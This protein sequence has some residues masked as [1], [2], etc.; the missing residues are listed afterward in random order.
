MTLKEHLNAIAQ[1]MAGNNAKPEEI[2]YA[3]LY[4]IYCAADGRI[5]EWFREFGKEP[6]YRLLDR[7]VPVDFWGLESVNAFIDD[8]DTQFAEPEL[9]DETFSELLNRAARTSGNG[10]DHI[11]PKELTELVYSLSNYTAGR[12]V[13][14]PYAGVGSY[15]GAFNAG[16]DYYGE[17]YENLTWAIGVVKMWMEGHPSTHYIQGDSLSPIWNSPFDVVVSTPPIGRIEGE[18]TTYSERLLSDAASLLKPHGSMVMVTTMNALLGQSGHKLVESGMLDMVISLPSNVLYWASYPP[19][20]V[21]LRNGRSADEPVCFVDGCEFF[22]PGGRGTRVINVSGLLDAISNK[23]SGIVAFVSAETLKKEEYRLAPALYVQKTV[24]DNKKDSLNSVH[25]RDLGEFIRPALTKEQPKQGI[26]IQDLTSNPC[27]IDLEPVEIEGGKEGFRLLDCSALLLFATV[28]GIKMGYAHASPERP[29]FVSQRIHIFI[30]DRNKAGIRY[31]AMKLAKAEIVRLGSSNLLITRDE[32]SLT[33]IP[34][35]PLAE[36]ERLVEK[37]MSKFNRVPSDSAII[38]SN[39]VQRI[40]SVEDKDILEEKSPRY[41]DDK[42]PTRRHTRRKFNIAFIG[43]PD[44]P[45]NIGK[46]FNIKQCFERSSDAEEWVPGNEKNLDAAI[47]RQSDEI[48]GTDILLFCNK[49]SIPVFI[50]TDDLPGLEETFKKRPEKIINRGFAPGEEEELYKTLQ[51]EVE[52]INSP[53]GQIRER[54]SVQLDAARN[55]DSMFP[56]R[57][58]Q[59][60][61][62]LEKILFSDLDNTNWINTLRTIRDDCFI[63]ILIDYGY[64]P[65][66]CKNFS[67]GAIASLIADRYYSPNEQ[68]KSN[69]QNKYYYIL[70]TEIVPRPLGALLKGTIQLLNEGSHTLTRTST[71]IQT[72]TLH[73]IMGLLICLSDMINEGKLDRKDSAKHW[74]IVRFDEFE[75]GVTE[76]VRV[77]KRFNSSEYLYAGNV[78][79]NPGRCRA[80]NIQEGDMVRIDF[81]KEEKEPIIDGTTRVWFY[82]DSFSKV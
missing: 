35:V 12:T 65:T 19:V 81:A 54:Y 25:L 27:L 80:I 3:Q 33:E 38:V 47:I 68:D 73:I 10:F 18:K 71:D 7:S 44:F 28:R 64:L 46:K 26:R 61:N 60:Q 49:V 1:E 43:V 41:T 13:Y 58:F 74:T 51:S 55:I 6:P 59:L 48:D 39:K 24:K 22:N 14:N 52:E 53:E 66:P 15:A 50:I 63:Q 23:A 82:S 36:Q 56:D 2:L 29:I 21:R 69:R 79:L 16:D 17:E 75:S 11:Q 57:D 45:E 4:L 42:E 31:I 8:E 30:P 32:L 77:Y 5:G 70:L 76:Q 72:A 67:K 34:I 20:I 40:T 78:H 37:A 62:T 9:L